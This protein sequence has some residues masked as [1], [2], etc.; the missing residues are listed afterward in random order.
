M[1]VMEGSEDVSEKYDASIEEQIGK[2]WRPI[3]GLSDNELKEWEDEGKLYRTHI[4]LDLSSPSDLLLPRGSS[5]VAS[6]LG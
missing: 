5:P 4:T 2:L 3:T 1:N 6:K